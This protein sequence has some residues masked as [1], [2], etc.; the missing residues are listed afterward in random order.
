MVMG[1]SLGV[2][3]HCA[4]A[5]NF[6]HFVIW[7]LWLVLREGNWMKIVRKVKWEDAKVFKWIEDQEK[8][9]LTP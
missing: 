1:L 4:A 3:C 7:V 2:I 5:I 8:K 9:L 6:C